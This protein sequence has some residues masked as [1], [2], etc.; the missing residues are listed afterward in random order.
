M[1]SGEEVELV[2]CGEDPLPEGLTVVGELTRNPGVR[3]VDGEGEEVHVT[4]R[5][6]DHFA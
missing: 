1:A 4:E 3:V 6:Y 2:C 5:G